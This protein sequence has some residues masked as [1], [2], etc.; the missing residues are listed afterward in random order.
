M[1]PTHILTIEKTIYKDEV[2]SITAQNNKGQ[3]TV[4][5]HHLPMMTQLPKGTITVKKKGEGPKYI[6]IPNKGIFELSNGKATI[7]LS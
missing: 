1:I 3:F 7:L 4:L 6:Q 5:P 2:E